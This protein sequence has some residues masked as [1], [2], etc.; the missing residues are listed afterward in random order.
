MFTLL[1]DTL[2]RFVNGQQVCIKSY[3]DLLFE[4][5]IT[6][7]SQETFEGHLSSAEKLLH[8]FLCTWFRIS[9]FI[10]WQQQFFLMMTLDGNGICKLGKGTGIDDIVQKELLQLCEK[11]FFTLNL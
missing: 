6:S 5:V 3:P 1:K 11:L 7:D 9:K 2:L 8:R 10:S 4:T